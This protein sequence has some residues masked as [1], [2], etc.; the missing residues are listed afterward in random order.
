MLPQEDNPYA[1]PTAHVADIAV[2]YGEREA[3]ERS[4]RLGA[5]LIDTGI[6][7]AINLPIIYFIDGFKQD[8]TLLEILR[9]TALGMLVFV[10]LQGVMLARHGQTIGK[11]LL[12][13]RIVRSDGTLA[14][15]WR[16][17]ALRYGVF[18]LLASIPVVGGIFALADSLF[19][20]RQSRKCLHDNLAD[21]IVIKA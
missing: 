14:N 17:L 7:L 5:V 13:I 9:N 3:A 20:F 12:K 11:R 6:L 2:V 19:I 10:L 18:S 8:P 4:T 15:I 16:L 21:T 1:P